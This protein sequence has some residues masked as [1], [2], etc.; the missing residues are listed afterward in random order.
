MLSPQVT[1]SALCICKWW[2]QGL[3]R[4]LTPIQPLWPFASINPFTH[5][6]FINSFY[7]CYPFVFFTAILRFDKARQ[8]YSFGNRG[9]EQNGEN[10][11]LIDSCSIIQSGN[12]FIFLVDKLGRPVKKAVEMTLCCLSLPVS[13]Y[14]TV[15]IGEM[16]VPLS[17]STYKLM[18]M[19]CDYTL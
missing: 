12:A 6:E 14:G 19:V 3:G 13:G 5:S 15:N 10:I 16:Q 2:A 11:E 1:C 4:R 7:G 8:L 17:P 18:F 9:R